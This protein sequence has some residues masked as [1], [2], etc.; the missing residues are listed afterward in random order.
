MVRDTTDPLTSR[1]K[2]RLLQ[3]GVIGHHKGRVYP[4]VYTGLRTTATYLE[5]GKYL[6]RVFLHDG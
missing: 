1:F 2:L 4:T 6:V 5:V 3:R